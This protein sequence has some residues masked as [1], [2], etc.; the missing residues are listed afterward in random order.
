MY[1]RE[2]ERARDRE[3]ETKRNRER[4]RERG[5]IQVE[6]SSLIQIVTREML[7][8]WQR[9]KEASYLDSESHQL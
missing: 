3:T 8:M 6:L 2:S 9:G 4:E 7:H 1:L 5:K